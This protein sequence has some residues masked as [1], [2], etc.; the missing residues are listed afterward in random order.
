MGSSH[1]MRRHDRELGSAEAEELFSTAQFGVLSTVGEGG[2]PYGVPVSFAY[3]GGR[4]YFHSAKEGH[5]VSNLEKDPRVS[6]C[7][8]GFAEAQPRD[9]TVHFR[10]AI[11]F[12]EAGR[13]G[14]KEKTDALR[15]IAAK[16][17]DRSAEEIARY[18][19]AE[20]ADAL[21]YRIDVDRM[22]AKGNAPAKK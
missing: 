8:V 20:G 1:S 4:I 15:S 17:T 13:V 11:A 16:Y 3:A 6:F 18:V 7:V 21:V 5:K 10:S 12:G 14:G 22:T 9:F 2:A 19:D